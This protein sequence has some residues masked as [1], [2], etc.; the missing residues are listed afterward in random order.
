[1]GVE[2]LDNL[3]PGDVLLLSHGY[4]AGWLVVLLCECGVRFVMRCDKLTGWSAVRK[5]L[6]AGSDQAPVTLNAPSEQDVADRG[7]PAD[8]PNMRVGRNVSSRSRVPVL[9]TN[10]D[11]QTSPSTASASVTTPAARSKKSSSG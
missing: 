2:A 10:L 8:V 11:P 9:A 7:C 5:V 1:M 3:C 6:R 4:P